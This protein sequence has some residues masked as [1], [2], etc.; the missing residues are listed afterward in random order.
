MIYRQIRQTDKQTDSTDSTD[1]VDRT[2]RQPSEDRDVVHDLRSNVLTLISIDTYIDT[3]IH[4]YR[5]TDNRH[6][7]R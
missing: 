6:T 4:A 7:N 2:N 3:Y 5:Q 1:R